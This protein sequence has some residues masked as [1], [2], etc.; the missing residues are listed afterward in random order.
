MSAY[1]PGPWI[2]IRASDKAGWYGLSVAAGNTHVANVV[3]QLD[4]REGANARLIAAAPELLEACRVFL[5]RQ[6]KWDSRSIFAG[7]W[8]AAQRITVT[9]MRDA[10]AK[11]EGRS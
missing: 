4:D 6:D 8:L 10:L 5:D 11:A 2:V 3:M 1:T 7:E 9:L